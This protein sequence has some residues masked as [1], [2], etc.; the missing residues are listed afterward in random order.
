MSPVRTIASQTVFTGK[1]FNVRQ[2]VV[3]ENGRRRTID[4]VEHALSY[5]VIARPSP[6]ELLLVSQ[7]RHAAGQVLLEIPA[8]MANP[9]ET[10]QAGALR[11]LREETGYSG[12]RIQEIFTLFPTPGFCDERLA[13]FLVDDLRCGATEFDDDEQIETRSVEIGKALA[14]LERGQIIDGKTALALLWLDRMVRQ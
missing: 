11:E 8:G 9:G 5:A 13:F 7:Y 2:D 6:G 3:E 14:L 4:L 10:A 12:G 1:V